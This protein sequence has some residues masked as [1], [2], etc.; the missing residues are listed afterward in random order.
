[1]SKKIEVMDKASVKALSGAVAQALSAVAEEYGIQFKSKGGKYDP[2]TGTF[3]PKVEFS[4]EDSGAR[5]FA[6][7]VRAFSWLSVSDY[8]RKFTSGGREFTLVGLNLR[9]PKFPIKA[10]DSGDGKTYRMT[11]ASLRSAL[12]VEVGVA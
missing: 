9:A 5:A 2:T 8:G 7:D 10:L 1:M 6:Q 11:E 12:N 4:L 3:S